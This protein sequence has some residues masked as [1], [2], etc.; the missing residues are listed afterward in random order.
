VVIDVEG[1]P[2]DL[3]AQLVETRTKAPDRFTV[4]VRTDESP[5]PARGTRRDLGRVYAVCPRSATRIRL[6]GRPEELEC[7]VCGHRGLVA[8]WETG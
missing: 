8:W 5:N 1:S 3:P 2:V 4:V 6:Y 7:P